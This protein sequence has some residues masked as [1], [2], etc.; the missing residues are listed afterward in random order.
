MS[1]KKL[2]AG[3]GY[4]YLTRQVAALD[5][6]EKG[7]TGLASYY[8][9]KGETPG[10]WVGSG[11]DGIDGLSAG[12]IVTADH[13]ANLFGA[14]HHPLATERAKQLDLRIG[15]PDQD[16]PT[17]A[18]YKE[19]TRLG[20]PYKVYENDI[21]ALR[22]EI[23]KRIAGLNAA[24]GMPADWPVTTAERAQIRT[25]VAR[26]FFRAEHGREPA[27][28]RELTAT[29]AKHSRPRTTAV[30]GF[31]L[32]FSPV[33]SVSTLWAVADQKTAAQIERAHQ[34]AIGDALAFIER[35]ALY[36][37]LGTNGVRQVDV[38]GL[39]AAAFTHRD[40]RAG[41]P[42]LHTH[43]AVANKVQTVDGKWRAI[44]G[45]VLY[46]ATVSASE[47][48][49]TALERRLGTRL[50]LRFAPRENLDPRKRVIR[51]VVGVDPR[52]NEQFSKR[53][54]SIEDRRNQ[55]AA[56]FQADH[57]RPPSPIETVR[58]AQQ[59]TLE[60][61]DAKHEPRSLAEQ[62]QAW[63]REAIAVLGSKDKVTRMTYA[64][65]HP[66]HR[67]K[68]RLDNAWIKT[69]AASITQTLQASRA[70]WQYWHV[71]AEAQRRVRAANTPP[72]K[73]DK[74]ID[75]L[76]AA[77]LGHH[78][79]NLTRSSGDN[80]TEPDELRR[81]DGASVYTV[82]GADLYTSA[83]VL[84]AEQRL[85]AA[86]G[87]HDG[88]A[89]DQSSVD[90]ALLES[91]GGGLKLNLGQATLV[92]EMAT[93]GARLQ[94]AI[95]PAGSGKTTAMEGL[96][97]AWTTGGGTVI[98]L[99]PQ[100]AA[101]KVL[102]ERI[103]SDADTLA[104]FVQ[105]I[106]RGT[107]PD[108]ATSIGPETLVVIDEAGMADTLSL[109]TATSYVL[110]R[111]G[112]VRLIGD[113]QQL[114]AIAAGGVLRDIRA[115][116]G[117][118]QLNELVRFSNPS[119]AAASLALRDGK[120]E[121]LG[122][123]LDHNRVHVGD[124]ATMTDDVFAAW[125]ADRGNSLD[126]M[127]LAPT[128]DLVTELNRRAQASRLAGADTNAA[129]LPARLAD[130]NHAGVGDTV[131]TRNNDRR[132]R[133]SATDW[134]KNGDRWGVVDT[135]PN[136][137]LT[138]QHLQHGRLVTLPPDYVRTHTRLGYAATIHSA[139]GLTCD[140]VHGLAT[141]QETRNLL[142]TQ[143]SRG[144]IANHIYL[145]VVGDGDPHSVIH[146][147]VTHPPTPT[148]ILESALARDGSQTSATSQLREQDDPT[149]QL[150][151]ATSR[152]V[153][154]LYAAAEYFVGADV[155]E[156]L[157]AT[158]EAVV[159]GIVDE[160]AWPA[161]RAHLLLLGAAGEDPGTRLREAAAQ[162]ELDTAHDRA[163]VLDWRLDS[164]GH[165]NTVTGPLPWLPAIPASLNDDP[166][167]GDYL[168]QRAQLVTT[169]ASQV[170]Q[171]ALESA[172]TS[173]PD[174]A[175]DGLRPDKAT[176]A[177]VEVWRA[178]TQVPTTDQRP[179]GRPQ[180]Q[181]AAATWQRQLDARITG[182][183]LPAAREWS[184]L[185][186]SLVPQIH[187]DDFAPH[188]ATRL[189]VMSRSGINAAALL[190]EAAQLRPLP[191]DHAAAALWW[192]IAH[193]IT[194]AIA[195]QI[196]NPAAHRVT[197]D[198]L[199]R[200]PDL[201]GPDRAQRIQD[202]PAWPALAANIDHGLQRGWQLDD[203]LDVD[204][205]AAYDDLDE[206]QTLVWRTSIA[207][208][209]IP[210][211]EPYDY[212]FD[213]PPADLW[214][215][216][217]P[218]DRP[219]DDLDT[220]S[221]TIPTSTPAVDDDH[222]SARLPDNGL[223]NN[224]QQLLDDLTVAAY[225]REL[226]TTTPLETTDAEIN[227]MLDRAAQ[228]DHC[229]ISE[230]RMLEINALAQSYFEAQY[231]D[232]WGRDYLAERFGIDLAGHEQVRPG[233]APAGWTN[234][235]NHLRRHGVADDEMLAAGVAKTARTGRLIDTF[236]DRVTFPITR[237]GTNGT[238][239]LG[240]VARRHPGH[241]G[242][243]D[244]PKYLNTAETPLFH[245]GAQLYGALDA[246]ADPAS[247]PVVVEG[248]TDA[249]AVTLASAG[250]YIGTAPL[251]TSLTVEQAQWL[252]QLGRDPVIARDGDLA[253]QTA[254]ER[255]FW[256][257]TP[258]GLDPGYAQL[259]TTADPAEI[260]TH[261]GPAALVA[262][263]DNHNP[264]ADELINERLTNRPADQAR[265]AAT[266]VAAARP[267][268]TWVDTADKIRT[269]LNLTETDVLGDL[270]DATNAWDADPRKAAQTELDNITAVRNR[271]NTAT[272]QEPEQRWA[273]LAASLDPRLPDQPDWPATA[274]ILQQAH[275]CGHDITAA[276][277]TL[278]EEAPLDNQP[279]QDLRYRLVARLDMTVDTIE[280]TPTPHS[281]ATSREEHKHVP[282]R[283]PE[284]RPAGHP[285]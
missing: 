206:A 106:E 174:W 243:K 55:L 76:V 283:S 231:T 212:G 66:T 285:R 209:T 215:G 134:V 247:T 188:L 217:H 251:G 47:V 200:L 282:D 213:D 275:D 9:E 123:Y 32:T 3:S 244:G 119:E 28:A 254:A 30:A 118:L 193:H 103:N 97:R 64:A 278:I 234:L 229:P 156:A 151:H 199:T 183:H 98:G 79:V 245:K 276:T 29:I 173:P 122:F 140:T 18:D 37:R 138:V 169:L 232:S 205:P 224:S 67:P 281:P 165:R 53:R 207:L 44:D 31:D 146:P 135:H 157:E 10:V 219:T 12:D 117:A 91:E 149:T 24:A 120:P 197:A 277:R 86:A 258:H 96:A 250:R 100:A 59:A 121:A 111:G 84:E 194:P 264:L 89:V 115:T 186:N 35:E 152:Y 93:S 190:K 130:D 70:T 176:V 113:D 99:A 58:L 261:G 204:A 227:Q 90:V 160:P 82:A 25:E 39:V 270:R 220:I 16:T 77:V 13:M 237:P 43:I 226:A 271:R 71:Y 184:H 65:L 124:L 45:R 109:D 116:H 131:I 104:A 155:A 150:G 255:D 144:A 211:D 272:Q 145:G 49:N 175:R 41:D 4:D 233:Q 62:R 163:A 192:R 61:R 177:D 172:E 95:A 50:G 196:D 252:A 187:T 202:S 191:D 80:I 166:H 40:S 273:P 241:N 284:Q 267:A 27:N 153:D 107:G 127:M 42:D 221:A 60:T 171:H 195:E 108:W 102:G 228:W 7:H 94:L 110:N 15:R 246:L 81:A 19:A 178:A 56:Q 143:L 256:R 240:F 22:V 126:A 57:G 137:G 54:L 114:S 33:K 161:L 248:P 51:E 78:S 2:T 203:L 214:D 129:A 85:V 142:Y 269:T 208:E 225:R 218:A 268:S 139:Q 179:T 210:A 235:V 46:K 201:L 263:I 6:T 242:E 112:S 92:R 128:H 68:P 154:S 182:T 8:T 63:Q 136:G 189:A 38:Q 48:Y 265:P 88:F 36:T 164:T 5:A 1:I 17:D 180:L 73:A 83:P 101:A 262:A 239:I 141:G 223:R 11:M 236:R 249:I 75:R 26:D 158:A 34:Q 260:L 216:V 21:P 280:T 167:W 170:H 105:A 181:K 238:E 230:T 125:Q 23:A 20:S 72:R 168:Q 198:W 132:L 274:R 222:T 162:R 253:G 147:E 87:C 52:L 266:K 14:G 69:T 148:D 133:V 74:T 259:P 279:A 185:L 257:L 159:P